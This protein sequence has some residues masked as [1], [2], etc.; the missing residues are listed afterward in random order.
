MAYLLR[1][2][3]FMKAANAWMRR[4]SAGRLR[5]DKAGNSVVWKAAELTGAFRRKGAGEEAKLDWGRARE[6][7]KPCSSGA[8]GRKGHAGWASS[9]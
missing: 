9:V 4:K 8:A 7:Q 6:I 3:I 5:Q 2:A 1:R